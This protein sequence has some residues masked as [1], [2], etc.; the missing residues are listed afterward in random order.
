M[1]PSSSLCSVALAR[2]QGIGNTLLCVPEEFLV[3]NLNETRYTVMMTDDTWYHTTYNSTVTGT[4]PCYDNYFNQ[5][6][7]S[8]CLS[9]DL[10]MKLLIGVLLGC[11]PWKRYQYCNEDS[12]PHHLLS[13][14]MIDMKMNHEYEVPYRYEWD[15]IQ[16]STKNH[17]IAPLSAMN[18]N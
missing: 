18:R 9:P 7:Q 5:W 13:I 12:S 8:M 17:F 1:M 16:Q 4:V 3:E 2:F 10:D 11:T 15:P 6:I 14:D